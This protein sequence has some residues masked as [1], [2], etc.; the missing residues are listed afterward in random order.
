MRMS[1]LVCIVLVVTLLAVPTSLASTSASAQAGGGTSWDYDEQ[2]AGEA[3]PTPGAGT[4][5]W[6]YSLSASAGVYVRGLDPSGSYA[7]AEAIATVSGVPSDKA[8]AAKSVNGSTGGDSE[9]DYKSDSGTVEVSGIEEV[10]IFNES[11]YAEAEG[12]PSI[13]AY[14]YA[15]TSASGSVTAQ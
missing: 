5:N 15:S 10:L 9:N 2:F 6:S 11:S 3:I 7:N 13:Q 12:G 1:H 14:A 4:Y 8:D